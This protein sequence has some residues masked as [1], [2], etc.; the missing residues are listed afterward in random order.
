MQASEEMHL[1]TFGKAELPFDFLYFAI[2]TNPVAH[3]TEGGSGRGQTTVLAA[4]RT[5]K[6]TV[7]KT[8]LL[9]VN[10]YATHYADR[11]TQIHQHF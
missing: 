7:I 4:S 1:P 6:P 9:H 10:K 2:R 8:I 3:R 11:T 5:T